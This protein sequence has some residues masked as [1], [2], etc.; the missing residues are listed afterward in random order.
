MATTGVNGLIQHLRH[1]V[2]RQD[3]AGLTDG[4]LMELY[5]TRREEA[6]FEALLHRHGPMVLGVCRRVLRNEA[7]AEDAFQATFLVFARKAASIRSR[8]TVSSWLYSVAHNM[9]LKA[10]AMNHKRRVK[11]RESGTAPKEESR[12]EVWQELQVLLDAEL[13]RLPDKYRVPIVLCDLEGKTIKDAAR[14]LGCPQGTLA[15]RLNRGRA[16]LAKRLARHG[17]VLSGSAAI[18]ALSHGEALACMPKAL[19][20][21]TIRAASLL[22]TAGQGAAAGVI[23]TKVAALT[24]GMMNSMLLTK[25]KVV[26]PL[27]LTLAFISVG[28]GIYQAE[29]APAE[30]PSE[31]A[32]S[33]GN[34][35]SESVPL[36]TQVRHAGSEQAKSIAAPT[37]NDGRVTSQPS[38][39]MVSK[40]LSLPLFDEIFVGSNIKVAITAGPVHR[41]K[42]SG[43]PERLRSLRARVEKKT[44]HDR[45]VLELKVPAEEAAADSD[46]VQVRITIPRLSGVIAR[47]AT[48]VEISAIKN[49]SLELTVSDTAKIKASGTSS[50]LNA[51]I[52]GS[53]QLD[54]SGLTVDEARVTASS[55]SS[56]L[57]CVHKS[58]NVLSSGDARVEYIGTPAQLHKITFDRSSIAWR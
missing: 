12:A 21:S 11:E 18:A 30:E 46:H 51:T 14:Q 41:V 43:A 31:I 8:N 49:E 5:V 44:K 37:Q 56:S 16:Q 36:N 19:I 17:L 25:L 45:L 50:S 35:I 6:A 27:T 22:A 4:E 42:A 24:E 28:R 33:H 13:S 34:G 32:T 52:D 38:D 10:K 2:L 29:A 53:G 40:D 48:M 57:F 7:D 58:L 20:D 1:A 9:A 23:S 3:G 54:A 47:G 26:I 55:Q 39:R 15:T